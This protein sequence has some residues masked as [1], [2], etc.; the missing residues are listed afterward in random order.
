MNLPI[1]FD[2]KKSLLLFGLINDFDFLKNLYQKKKLP[3]VSLS[4]HLVDVKNRDKMLNVIDKL[5]QKKDLKS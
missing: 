1:Y 5:F 4:E 3:N 2:P